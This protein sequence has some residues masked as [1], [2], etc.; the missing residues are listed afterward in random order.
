MVKLLA[1]SEMSNNFEHYIAAVLKGSVLTN[2]PFSS[3]S[4]WPPLSS[5][6]NKH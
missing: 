6:P 5:S 1:F 3:I 2:N 4:N